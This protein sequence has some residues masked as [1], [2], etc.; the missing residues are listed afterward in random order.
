VTVK[1]RFHLDESVAPA[2]AEGL[3]RRGIDVTTAPE[4]G[5]SSADDE[6]QLAFALRERRLLVTQDADFLRL[7]RRG[8]A[9]AGIAY[10]DPGTRTIGQLIA[11]LVLIHEVLTPEEMKGQVEFL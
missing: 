9:H 2:V 4:V 11:G 7:H 6:T 3:R 8:L 5:L 1:I 10:Y